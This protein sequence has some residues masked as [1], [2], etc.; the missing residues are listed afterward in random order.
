MRK[1]RGR[2]ERLR[3]SLEKRGGGARKDKKRET[4]GRRERARASGGEGKVTA[5][6]S[7]GPI[8]KVL[9]AR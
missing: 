9:S 1:R 7:E 4:G 6:I 5:G 2:V 3:E 8:V